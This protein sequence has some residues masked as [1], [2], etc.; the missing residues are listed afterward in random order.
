MKTDILLC[1]QGGQAVERW[2]NSRGKKILKAVCRVGGTEKIIGKNLGDET[3][4][5]G[6][7]HEYNDAISLLTS[8]LYVHVYKHIFL[9]M[10]ISIKILIY[11]L[12]FKQWN[13]K[14]MKA[15]VFIIILYSDDYICILL[16]LMHKSKWQIHITEMY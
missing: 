16:S 1:E 6:C 9:R 11:V 3:S 12:P 15:L 8:C 7:K 2:N 4:W 10:F 14:L 5:L 13:P